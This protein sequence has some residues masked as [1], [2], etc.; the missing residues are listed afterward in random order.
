M[1]EQGRPTVA[2]EVVWKEDERSGLALLHSGTGLTGDFLA[3]V[4][5]LADPLGSTWHDL[6]VLARNN[7]VVTVIAARDLAAISAV[8][9]SLRKSQQTDMTTKES[10]S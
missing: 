2:A 7:D 9:Q 8:A 5:S 10:P 1:L 6:E 3:A 4:R